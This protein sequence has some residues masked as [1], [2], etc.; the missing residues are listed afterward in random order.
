MTDAD[1][2]DIDAKCTELR[3][4]EREVNAL[5]HAS[6]DLSDLGDGWHSWP[7][8]NHWALVKPLDGGRYV[9]VVPMLFTWRLIV[10]PVE[11]VLYGHADA[12]CYRTCAAAIVAAD[13]WSGEGE[14][15]GWHKHPSSGRRR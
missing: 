3:E 15:E 9:A 11:C 10:G 12:W 14:P 13:A 8:G 5:P 4:V 2:I 6:A 7:Y 1:G